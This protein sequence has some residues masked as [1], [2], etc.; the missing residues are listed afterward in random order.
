MDSYLQNS[1]QT[2]RTQLAK[3]WGSVCLKFFTKPLLDTVNRLPAPPSPPV[4]QISSP[5]AQFDN[6]GGAGSLSTSGMNIFQI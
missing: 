3:L 2:V 1:V 4:P 6:V 5:D